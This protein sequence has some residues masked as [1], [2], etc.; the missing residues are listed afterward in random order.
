MF[1]GTQG[2]N[3]H[4]LKT[5]AKTHEPINRLLMFKQLQYR[6]MSESVPT[7]KA[8]RCKYDAVLFGASTALVMNISETRLVKNVSSA[9]SYKTTCC[10]YK[11]M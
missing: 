1:N 2:V 9:I 7:K 6:L 8:I 4:N 3:L 10:S 11:K 5:N